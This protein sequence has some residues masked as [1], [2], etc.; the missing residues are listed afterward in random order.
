MSTGFS[1]LRTNDIRTSLTCLLHV[2]RVTNHLD[3]RQDLSRYTRRLWTA[4]EQR[5]K[6]RPFIFLVFAIQVSKDRTYVHIQNAIFVQFF[7]HMS[8]CDTNRRDEQLRASRDNYV[9]K[10]IEVAFCVIEL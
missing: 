7:Y 9:N 8:R 1:T 4:R 3:T 6:T 5:P 2:L 10:L